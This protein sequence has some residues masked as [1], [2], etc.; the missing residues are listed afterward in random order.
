MRKCLTF[1]GKIGCSVL[2]TTLLTGFG[3]HAEGGVNEWTIIGPFGGGSVALAVGGPSLIYVGTYD[4]TVFRSS[5]SG[6]RWDPI[7]FM[8]PEYDFQLR[9]L[10]VTPSGV[11]YGGSSKGGLYRSTDEG[12]TWKSL[13]SQPGLPYKPK[14]LKSDEIRTGILDGCGSSGTTVKEGHPHEILLKCQAYGHLASIMGMYLG[15]P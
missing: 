7:G 6:S 1:L 11:M 5:S 15:N 12:K 8:G 3:S 13:K 4:G 2:L 9:T 14:D 10:K